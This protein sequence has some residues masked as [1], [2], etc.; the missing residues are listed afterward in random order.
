M[1]PLDLYLACLK[2]DDRRNLKSVLKVFARHKF[3][4]FAYGSTVTNPRGK[5]GDIDI[6]VRNSLLS[7]VFIEL[8]NL[9]AKLQPEAGQYF[10]IFY[11]G[12]D[13]H[14]RVMLREDEG[15]NIAN[16]QLN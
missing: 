9:G 16:V 12:S 6:F 15:F 13:I 8:D 3:K 10:R 2:S 4:V 11:N 14:L 1:M 7:K 5:Y